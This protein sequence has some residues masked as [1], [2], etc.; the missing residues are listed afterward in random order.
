MQCNQRTL[1][2]IFEK[3]PFDRAL[4]SSCYLSFNLTAAANLKSSDL[5]VELLNVALA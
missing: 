5:V 1:I 4:D 3:R 2:F